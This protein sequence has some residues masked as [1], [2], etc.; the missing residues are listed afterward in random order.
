MIKSLY[1]KAVA[2]LTPEP[3]PKEVVV[4]P[5]DI[6]VQLKLALD[7]VGTVELDL[8]KSPVRLGRI[9]CYSDTLREFNTSLKEILAVL[10]LNEPVP[11]G[12]ITVRELKSVPFDD[13]LFVEEG[14][15]VADATPLLMLAFDQI[16]AYYAHMKN[17]SSAAYGPLE[18]SH[19]ALY[20]YTMTLT[21]FVNLVIHHFGT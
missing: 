20:R 7:L 1:L 6:Y 18:Q 5:N 16:D 11:R 21:E 9:E 10:K 13:F 14:H 8:N 19:R 15:Y 4:D 17:A 12:L 3:L 2:L